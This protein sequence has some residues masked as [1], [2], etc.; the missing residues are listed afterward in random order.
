MA[1][2]KIYKR[3]TVLSLHP[4]NTDKKGTDYDGFCVAKSKGDCLE[5][6]DDSNNHFDIVKGKGEVSLAG[7]YSTIRLKK[8]RTYTDLYKGN[9]NFDNGSDVTDDICLYLGWSFTNA[10][11]TYVKLNTIYIRCTDVKPN[12]V[13]TL[14]EIDGVKIDGK[15]VKLMN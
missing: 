10:I 14:K 15:T 5:I 4:S 13:R 9:T 6:Y 1:N 12:Q 7:M 11:K 8:F 2:V 3:G